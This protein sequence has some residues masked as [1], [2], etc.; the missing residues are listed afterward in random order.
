MRRLLG[1]LALVALTALPAAGSHPHSGPVLTIDPASLLRLRAE[2]KPVV[3]IDVRP[4]DAYAR[5]RLPGARSI[6]LDALVPRRAEVAPGAIVVLYGM[7]TV[8]E[9][10]PAA[11][12]LRGTGHAAVFVL[13]GGFA[14]WQARGLGVEP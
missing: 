2:Q 6:P 3:L 8:D 1:A 12:Y 7:N 10:A 13:E 5:G 4:P 14:G 9:A 11:R